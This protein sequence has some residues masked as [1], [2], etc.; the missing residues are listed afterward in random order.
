M[1]GGGGVGRRVDLGKEGKSIGR[2]WQRE[3]G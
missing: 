3:A 2:K 1:G